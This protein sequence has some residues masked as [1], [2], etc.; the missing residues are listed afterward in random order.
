MR[1]MTSRRITAFVLGM[2]ATATFA[3]SAGPVRSKKK[4]AGQLSAPATWQR[5]TEKQ[6]LERW[7]S[8]PLT[9]EPNIGQTDSQVRFLTRSGG[10]TSFLTDRENVMVLSRT[11]AGGGAGE[12]TGVQQTVVRMKI[13]GASAPVRFEGLEPTS[14]TSNYF[15]GKDPGKWITKV[16]NY[17]KVKASGVYPGVDLLYYGDGRKLEFDFVVGPGGD[18]GKIRL[19]YEGADRLTTDSAGNLL[20]A[21]SIGTIVQHRPLV[22]Q[23][24]NGQRR[25]VDVAYTIH[26]GYVQFAVAQ[27]DRGKTL[28]I[29]PTLTYG[30][31]LGGSGSDTATSVALQGGFIYVAGRTLSANFPGGKLPGVPPTG[32]RGNADAFVMKIDPSQSGAASLIY[33]TYLSGSGNDEAWGVAVDGNG[34]AYVT[35]FTESGDF[36]VIAAYQSS[37]KGGRDLFLSKLSADGTAL[38]YSTYFGG[39]ADEKARGIALDSANAAYL[40]GFTQSNDFPV[41]GPGSQARTQ[42]SDVFIAKFAPNGSLQYSTCTGASDAD[43][44]LGDNAMLRRQGIAVAGN[45]IY[46]AGTTDQNINA[47]GARPGGGHDAFAVR[48]STSTGFVWGTYIGGSN[49]DYGTAVAA[50]A[51]SVYVT[52]YAKSTIAGQST[53][54]DFDAYAAKLDPATGVLNF[55]RYV[56]GTGGDYGSALAVDPQGR[57]WLT[58]WAARTGNFPATDG[59]NTRTGGTDSWDV[60]VTEVDPSAPAAL[61]F[62]T[63]ISSDANDYSFAIAVAGG[64]PYIAGETGAPTSEPVPTTRNGYARA[65]A[66]GTDGFV[67]GV[68]PLDQTN[69]LTIINGNNQTAPINTQFPIALTVKVTDEDGNP[70]QEVPVTFKSPDSG[71]SADLD[72]SGKSL[73]KKTDDNGLVSV[74]ATANGTIGTYSVVVSR[75]SDS[76]S[77]TLTNGTGLPASLTF[78]QQPTN[79]TAGSTISA[80]KVRVA[81]AANNSI[82][83]KAVTLA[84]QGGPGPLMGTLTA[85]TDGNGI[86]TFSNLQINTVGTY[87]LQASLTGV[88]PATSTSFQ[89]TAASSTTITAT[90]GS[91]QSTTVTT[92][93]PSQLSATVKDA[94]GNAVPNVTVTFTL[95]STGASGAFQGTLLTA[96]A[97]TNSSGVANSPV[98]TANATPG[99]FTASASTAG[100]ASS[101]S[102]TLTN[103]PGTASKLIFVQGP[104]DAI[105]GATITPHVTVQLQDQFG[106]NLATSGIPVTLVL[107]TGTLSGTVTR[108]TNTS[109]VA[110]F[111]DLN[112]HAAGT[113]TLTAASQGLGSAVSNSFTIRA[114]APATVTVAGGATQSTQVTTQFRELLKVTVADQFGNPVSGATVT[115]TAPGT[116]ASATFTTPAATDANGQTTVRATA[117]GIAGGYMVSATTGAASA[118]QFSLT[119]T[120]GAPGVVTFETQPS[121]TMAGVTINPVTVRVTDGSGNPEPPGTSVTIALQEPSATLNGTLTK[122]TGANGEVTFN[123]LTVN[124]TGTYHLVATAGGISGTSNVFTISPSNTSVV[125]TAAQGNGQSTTVGAAFPSQLAAKVADGYGNAISG[126]TVTFTLP[127]TGASGTFPGPVPTATATTNSSGIAT[128]PVVTAS[129][130]P[131][132]FA[133]AASTSGAA[134]NATFVLTNNA[135]TGSKLQFTQGPTDAAAGATIAPSVTVQVQDQFGNNL[136]TLGIPVTLVLNSGALSGTATQFTNGSG[137]ATFNDLNVH[138]AGTYTLTAQAPALNS[139]V[140]NSFTVHAGA[141]ATVAVSGGGTQSAQVLTPFAQPLQATVTDA[142]GN[143]VSGATVTYASPGTGASATLSTAPATDANGRTS[144]TATA[145]GT[146]GGYTVTATAGTGTANFALTNTAGPPG[147]VTFET[148]PSNTMAGATLNPITVKVLDG[149]GNP[150]PPG[151]SVT[152]KLQEPHV[153]LQGTLTGTTGANGEVTFS[154]LAVNTTGTFHLV[155]TAATISGVSNAFTISPANSSIVITAIQGNGQSAVVGGPYSGPLQVMVADVYGNLISGAAV[156]FT[157]PSTGASATFSGPATVMT[158]ADGLA[159]SPALTANST[160]GT[161]QVSATTTGAATPALFTLTNIAAT[162]NSL[163]FVQQPTDTVAG[164]TITPAVTVQLADSTGQPVHT[165]GVP[166]AVQANAVIMRRRLFS[167]TA[168]E[169]TDANGLATFADLSIGAV[170]AYTLQASSTGVVSATSNLFHITA[171]IP[172]VIQSTG[173]QSQ[174]AFVLTVFGAPLQVTV[175]DLAGNPSSGVTVTFSAPLS[176]PSGTFGGQ[177]SVTAVTDSHGQAHAVITANNIAG[178]YNVAAT[179]TGVT[180]SAMFAL[181]NLPVTS[182]LLKFITQP[183]NTLA[184]QIIAPPVTV[185]L[186]TGTGAPSNTAGVAVVMTLFSGTGTLLGT[187]VQ[188]TDATGTA[189][190][191]DLRI[192]AAGTKQ[193]SA[194]TVSTAPV[195]S[196]AFQI[197]AGVPATITSIAGTPQ[198]TNVSQPFPLQLQAQVLDGAGNPVPGAAVT[199]A[200]P[201][202][203]P[204]GTFGGASTVV[205]NNNGVA[206]SPVLTANGTSGTFA[207]PATVVGVSSPAGFA[208]TNLPQSNTISVDTSQLSFSSTSGQPA[209][210]GQTVQVTNPAGPITWTATPS[211]PWIVVTPSSGTTPTTVT[212]SVNPSGLAPGNYTG[213]VTFTSS[214]GGSTAVLVTYSIAN[215]PAL[216]ITPP[217]LVFVTPDNTIAPAAQTLQATSST[218]AI[219]YRV[220]AQVSTPTGGTWLSVSPGSG[221]TVGSVQVSVSPAGLAQG[222]YNGSVLFTPTDPTINSVAVPVSLLLGCGQGGCGAQPII[223]TVVNGA[224]F[225]PSGAPGAAMTIFGIS[226]SDNTYQAPSYPLPTQLGPT[227]VTVNGNL[228]PLYYASPTQINFQMPSTAPPENVLVRVSNSS[229]Q[230]VTRFADQPH[231]SGLTAVDPGLFVTAGNRA[232]ALNQDLSLNTPATPVPAGGVILLYITGQGPITPQLPDGTAAPANPLSLI[233]GTVG[234]MIGGKPANV[235]YAGVAPGFAGLSQINAVIPSGLVPGDQPVFVT[236]DGVSSNA[237]LITTK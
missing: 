35:G 228:V 201:A 200:A 57:I 177:T 203:G 83:G 186:Q 29:D 124:T 158:G 225:H 96:T 92:A 198:A 63:R 16:P 151:T 184:G 101:A 230:T 3:V 190:F 205:T 178:G 22:Y 171:G 149:S 73:N 93:F 187:A 45:G 41:V 155:A 125:I 217:A 116:G 54:G 189:T 212:I 237:G 104:T 232:A 166:I 123:D 160:A 20:I 180:G 48:W 11:K 146:A 135:G 130:T 150:E 43:Y 56:G 159:T 220:S 67:A 223:I 5:A 80:V 77:F 17:R 112:V 207:V 32:V 156:T 142:F 37:S 161:F 106:N 113:Y 195:I 233:N 137:V 59:T 79:T 18:P 72:S 60:F 21:T 133:A 222:I 129:T 117:N 191:N 109:G 4:T 81:D 148:Q 154:D 26:N 31:Y 214:G 52:G 197:T 107:N 62:S 179:A 53:S 71:A 144:V 194:A 176:G 234:V 134:A 175:T 1:S 34:Q 50:D 108:L 196:S 87:T 91:G 172:A 219:S 236:I 218:G 27:W 162:P 114:G 132:S 69:S 170:G 185:Q 153:T 65:D 167:G 102:F 181:N 128:S 138:A 76:V 90:G 221:Q 213:I 183:S 169:N 97:T 209:P 2:C 49:E 147:T 126:A 139:A 10:M 66:G 110:V 42:N 8:Q 88:S 192:G 111:E 188:A 157:A 36:P 229:I 211:A 202:S 163:L 61:P 235:V 193:L 136:T 140:S 145:N 9:F 227:T 6:A 127:S 58:G 206:V 33:S 7:M 85:V 121:N 165:A 99:S 30:S 216:V 119:N 75:S 46:V 44:A 64:V 98:V 38:Q 141:P 47:V 174:S 152:I 55:F 95:P 120:A 68:N 78:T 13:E 15:T 173:G 182:T 105:A 210:P 23:E 74:V 224:S 70:A 215:K 115:Y 39:T 51:N 12:S 89:I 231:T 25:A 208:L 82:S 28:V 199:F 118:A 122:T 86:A 143:P 226:L 19:A 204:G 164:Q 131:G 84:A 168:T 40:T 100:A 103:N 14:S 24:I 94:F